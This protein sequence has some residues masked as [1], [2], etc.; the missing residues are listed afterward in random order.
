LPSGSRLMLTALVL[1]G[2]VI[3]SLTSVMMPIKPTPP[4]HDTLTRIPL[5]R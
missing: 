2:G 4:A 3:C 1:L 5:L